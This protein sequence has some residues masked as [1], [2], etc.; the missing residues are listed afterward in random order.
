[1]VVGVATKVADTHSPTYARVT[2]LS[3][4]AVTVW[5]S[6]AAYGV[7]ILYYDYWSSTVVTHPASRLPR[8][9]LTRKLTRKL[10]TASKVESGVGERQG[11]AQWRL[12]IKRSAVPEMSLRCL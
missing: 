1:M 11:A 10:T 6:G 12:K 8:Y 3:R 4:S 5:F 2:V 7:T 9:K